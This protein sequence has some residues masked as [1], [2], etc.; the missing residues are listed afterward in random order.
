MLC[1]KQLLSCAKFCEIL[2]NIKKFREI[3]QE[4]LIQINVRLSGSVHNVIKNVS[5]LT[6][7]YWFIEGMVK[8]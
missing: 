3:L 7:G 4:I 6:A 2:R 5:L 1:C 8:V